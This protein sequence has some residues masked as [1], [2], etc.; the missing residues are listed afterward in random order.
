MRSWRSR[1]RREHARLY[2]AYFNSGSSAPP[3]SEFPHA[4]VP[5]AAFG[6]EIADLP[7]EGER[8]PPSVRRAQN[9]KAAWRARACSRGVSPNSAV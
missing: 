3:R 6:L 7:H 2:G 9:R 8:R 4:V 5:N 1:N